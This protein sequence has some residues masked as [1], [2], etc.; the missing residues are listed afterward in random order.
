MALLIAA[1]ADIAAPPRVVWSVLT[2]LPRYA[3]WCSLLRHRG[4]RMGLGERLQLRLELPKNLG[5]SYD[6]VPTIVAFE[7]ERELAWLGSTGIRGVFDGLHRFVLTP[8]G[9]GT[10][11]VNE[12]T[13]SGLLLPVMRGML[14]GAQPGYAALTAEIK[15]RAEALVGA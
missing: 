10:H 9:L 13:F 2:D 3:E 7:V 14:R 4:G 6:F 1:E 5:S 15:A 12:E 11:L 8:T